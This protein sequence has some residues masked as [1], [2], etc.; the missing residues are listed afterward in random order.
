[1]GGLGNGPL[2]MP[3]EPPRQG[4]QRHSQAH[5]TLLQKCE[6][7]KVSPR[8]I[9]STISYKMCV[10]DRMA[11]VDVSS[12]EYNHDCCIANSLARADERAG[13]PG[14]DGRLYIGGATQDDNRGWLSRVH[15][16]ICSPCPHPVLAG[17][18][19][20]SLG[21]PVGHMLQVKKCTVSL[22][23]QDYAFGLSRPRDPEGAREGVDPPAAARVYR[24]H[25]PTTQK[26]VFSPTQPVRRRPREPSEP[27]PHVHDTA[28]LG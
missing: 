7:G 19:A 26:A 6:L 1:M 11:C 23:P 25:R 2:D 14:D 9:P 4:I 8:E 16:G 27:V 3:G 21:W 5:N 18:W 13:N 24:A 15:S 22:P 12:E 17:A 20:D 10:L 28:N